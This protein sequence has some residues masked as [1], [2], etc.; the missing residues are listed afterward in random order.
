MLAADAIFEALQADRQHD[1]VIAY[2]TMY[3]ESWLYQD[4]Y[5]SRNFSPAI[6]R[7]GLF[8]GGLSPLSSTT[9]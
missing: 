6:H 4:N 3:K 5:E 7:M 2:S 1:E 8:M 9:S